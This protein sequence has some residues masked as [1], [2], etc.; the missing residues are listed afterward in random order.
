MA[1]SPGIS[2]SATSVILYGLVFVVF[3][4]VYYGATSTAIATRAIAIVDQHAPLPSPDDPDLKQDLD[5]RRDLESL[6]GVT[7]GTRQTHVHVVPGAAPVPAER[8]DRGSNP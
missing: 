1:A 5:R 4:G 6:V 3:L 2:V 8:S 7:A